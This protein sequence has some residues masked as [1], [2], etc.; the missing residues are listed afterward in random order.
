M[1]SLFAVQ[2]RMRA[3]RTMVALCGCKGIGI[4]CRSVGKRVRS[5]GQT[6]QPVVL[7]DLQGKGLCSKEAQLKKAFI[8]FVH[9]IPGLH[10]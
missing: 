8:H 5:K 1:L 4:F 3:G 10:E 6:F 9:E 2:L 7:A